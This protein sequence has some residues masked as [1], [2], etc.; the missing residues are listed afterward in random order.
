VPDDLDRFI[1]KALRKNQKERYQTAGQLARDLRGLKQKLQ[2]DSGLN[3]WLKTVPSRKDGVPILPHAPVN[4]RSGTHR[5]PLG[6]GT[7]TDTIT[8]ESHPTSSA[9]YLI[10][11]IKHHKRG[12]LLAAAALIIASIVIGYFYAARNR[13]AAASEPIDS[14]AVLPFVN[15]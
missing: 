6:K 14:V 9:E 13:I 11:E 5:I 10:S 15:V 12:V 8:I 2:V 3:Q 4:T 1:T 7:A